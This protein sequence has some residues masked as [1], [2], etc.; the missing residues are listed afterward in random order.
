MLELLGIPLVLQV[1]L[2]AGLL[3]WLA[4]G[5]PASRAA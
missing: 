5:R 1:V 3:L 2:P 4:L